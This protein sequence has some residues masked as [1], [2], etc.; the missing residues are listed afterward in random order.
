MCPLIV[1][2]APGIFLT[3]VCV[4]PGY[5]TQLPALIAASHAYLTGKPA[6]EWMYLMS[7]ATLGM[8]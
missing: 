7:A 4:R 5:D 2:Y 3:S 8:L 1:L 6:V